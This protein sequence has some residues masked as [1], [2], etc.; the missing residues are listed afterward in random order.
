VVFVDVRIQRFT[1]HEISANLAAR[2]FYLLELAFAEERHVHGLV[3]QRARRSCQKY[4]F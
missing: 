2:A 4:P 3:N 1:G